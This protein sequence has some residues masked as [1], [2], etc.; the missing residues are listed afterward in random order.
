MTALQFVVRGVPVP[1]GSTRAFVVGKRAIV[2]NQTPKLTAWRQAIASEARLV[3][4]PA[5]FEGAL[6]VDVRFAF[7]A[8]K[9]NK[10]KKGYKSTRPDIDKLLRAVLDGCTGVV[11]KDDAQVAHVCATKTYEETSYVFVWVS[12]C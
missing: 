5:L 7:V 9:S 4:P 3:A 11:W 2:T 10:A 12:T 6:S 8:A 1:Q